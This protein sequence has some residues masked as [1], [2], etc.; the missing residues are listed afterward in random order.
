MRA[1]TEFTAAVRSG[2]RAGSPSLV[3]HL[4][5]TADHAASPQ[6]GFIVTRSVGGAVVRN[7]VRRRLRHVLRERL[8]RLPAGSRLVVR[9]NPAAAGRSAG[10]LA[11]DLDRALDRAL[12]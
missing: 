7:T 6:V 10:Q 9:V 11:T 2:V 3:V 12:R 5:R 1:R 8:E 4:G